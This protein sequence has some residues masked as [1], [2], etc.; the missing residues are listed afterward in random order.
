MKI[1]T[2][3]QRRYLKCK[4]P[5]PIPNR[6]PDSVE[7]GEHLRIYILKDMKQKDANQNHNKPSLHTHQDGYNQNVRQQQVLGR[8]QKNWNLQIL[9]IEQKMVQSL[10]KTAQQFLNRLNIDFLY[11]PAVLLR[12]IP[13]RNGN[14]S[15]QKLKQTCSQQCYS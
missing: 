1:G 5:G 7:L 8:K 15:T 4:F 9:L 10:W 3:S 11:D 2:E 12:Y 6:V 14:V 13:K